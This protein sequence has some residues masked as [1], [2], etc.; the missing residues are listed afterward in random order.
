M[1][2]QDSMTQGHKQCFPKLSV[3]AYTWLLIKAI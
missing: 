3:Y 2:T 1:S